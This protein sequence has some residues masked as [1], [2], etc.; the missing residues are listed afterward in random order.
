M[1]NQSGFAT[2]ILSYSPFIISANETLFE[3]LK[4]LPGLE[5]MCLL[6]PGVHEIFNLFRIVDK[7]LMLFVDV[8]DY[9]VTTLMHFMQK[10]SYPQMVVIAITA[11]SDVQKAIG[12]L[13]IGMRGIVMKEE[14]NEAFIH[15]IVN[16]YPNKGFPISNVITQSIIQVLVADAKQPFD[17]DLS[18]REQQILHHL[19]KGASYKMIASDLEISIETVRHHI[20]RLYKKLDIK[21]KGEIMS[22]MMDTRTYHPFM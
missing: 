2:C 9:A 4:C 19:T 15:D 5:N 7:A 1:M 6:S 20:K 12:F 22:K 8:D 18:K 14:L 16:T 10:V 13:R 17:A 21:S 3:T 11:D